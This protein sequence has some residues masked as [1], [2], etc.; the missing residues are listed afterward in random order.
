MATKKLTAGILALSLLGGAAFASEQATTTGEQ[1]LLA[2]ASA[3]ALTSASAGVQALSDEEMRQIEAGWKLSVR[4][5]LR[6]LKIEVEW[7]K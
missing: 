1:D 6:P 5:K 3:G 2:I 4:L 7:K